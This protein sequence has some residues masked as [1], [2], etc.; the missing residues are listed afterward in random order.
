M[1][2]N[3]IL[4]FT[5]TSLRLTN[6][7]L[8]VII[9]ARF[10]G[11][12]EFGIFMYPYTLAA[13]VVIL[14][15]YGFNLQL[16]KDIGKN[17]DDAHELTCQALVVKTFLVMMLVL[18]GLPFFICDRSLEGYR[19]LL[20]LLILSNVLNS[21][22]VLLNLSFRGRELYEI[23]ANATFWM[24][25]VTFLLVGG[26]VLSG[27]GPTTIAVGFVLAK[28]FYLVLSWHSYKRLNGRQRL[29]YPGIKVTLKLLSAG[30]PFAAHLALG[31]IYFSV[32]TIII[33]HLLGA[34]SVGIYQAGFRIMFGGLILTDVFSN[35]YL[36]RMAQDYR[37]RERLIDLATKMTRYCLTIGVVGLI[38]TLGFNDVLVRIVYGKDGFTQ[39]A[40]L[41]PFFGVVLLL[42][43]IAAS[44]GVLLTVSEKQVVR[45]VGVA[46]SVLVS[47]VLNLLLV[48]RYS[49]H[50]AV[51]ASIL[52]HVLLTAIYILFAVLQTKT[53]LT[54]KR[55]WILAGIA[56]S[57][58]VLQLSGV[59]EHHLVR[60]AITGGCLL[61]VGLVGIHPGEYLS[62]IH[63]VQVKA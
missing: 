39:V 17:I 14:V 29:V 43:Y 60:Y 63:R 26:L 49:L 9:M 1:I 36:S 38:C 32:D 59:L 22:G 8:L 24:S 23:E 56:A 55:T 53:T 21:Y 46:L 52:T 16:V 11:P 18:V 37:R 2:R 30:F 13:L 10:W 7:V 35:V 50:G 58:L 47:I 33:Q 27:R 48:P 6:S 41:L 28:S 42:R 54:D 25:I 31:T 3:T 57:L 12:E 61:L 40:P 20:G 15:D 5:S 45:T 44:Y 19:L 62:I 51:Y 34:Q 4:M